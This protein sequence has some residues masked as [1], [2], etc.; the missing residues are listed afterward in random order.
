MVKR[1]SV[2]KRGHKGKILA[3]SFFLLFAL[4]SLSVATMRPTP[5]PSNN[6]TER[7]DDLNYFYGGLLEGQLSGSVKAVILADTDCKMV[8]QLIE[9]ITECTAIIQVDDGDILRFD[10]RHN[11]SKQP[12]LAS[13][14]PVAIEKIG[15]VVRVTRNI[16]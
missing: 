14:E 12:R 4:I 16:A 10:Y 2:K 8:K 5:K 6:P 3:L 9:P 15:E 11:M 13:G 7:L 1:R